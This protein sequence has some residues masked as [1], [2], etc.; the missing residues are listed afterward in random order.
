VRESCGLCCTMFSYCILVHNNHHI[1][2]HKDDIDALTAACKPVPPHSLSLCS[3]VPQFVLQAASQPVPQS[4]LIQSAPRAS[5]RSNQPYSV[6][7]YS[8]NCM[9]AGKRRVSRSRRIIG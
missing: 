9:P 8:L 2:H 5:C 1:Q 3:S 7:F 4:A 6:M